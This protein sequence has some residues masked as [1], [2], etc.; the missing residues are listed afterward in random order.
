M[1]Y[2]VYNIETLP[3]TIKEKKQLKIKTNIALY[4]ERLMKIVVYNKAYIVFNS[5]NNKNYHDDG[6]NN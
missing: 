3:N 4:N 2:Y 6:D 5:K 1:N